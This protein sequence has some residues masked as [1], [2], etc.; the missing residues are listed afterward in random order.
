MVSKLIEVAYYR[1]NSYGRPY[2][3]KFKINKF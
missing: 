3:T 2:I 1:S